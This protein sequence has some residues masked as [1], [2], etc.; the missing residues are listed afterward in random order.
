M[1]EIKKQSRMLIGVPVALIAL[2][3]LIA[4]FTYFL[5][6]NFEIVARV[7]C[8][9]EEKRCFYDEEDSVA[10]SEI[11]VPAKL[12]KNTCEDLNSDC[13]LGLMGQDGVEQIYCHGDLCVRGTENDKKI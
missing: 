1:N 12:L 8:Q 3:F 2:S 6:L 7:D 13:L 10:Y 11:R 4:Y 5:N 9:S